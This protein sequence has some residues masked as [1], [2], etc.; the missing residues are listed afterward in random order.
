MTETFLADREAIL[1]KYH[2]LDRPYN[3]FQ[4]FAYPRL[5][6][7]P[8]TGLDDAGIPE[9]IR[10]ACESSAGQPHPVVQGAGVCRRAGQHAHSHQ[11]ARLVCGHLWLGTAAAGIHAQCVEP[12]AV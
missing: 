4:R 8:D 1:N 2:R 12:A 5:G 9:K 7:R 11:P 6:V 10:E 3:S